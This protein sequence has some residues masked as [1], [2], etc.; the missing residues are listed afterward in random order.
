MEFYGGPEANVIWRTSRLMLYGVQWSARLANTIWSSMEGQE[1]NV[2]RSSMEDQQANS[3]WSSMEVQE[4]NALW[5]AR[6]L[7]LY[8]GPGG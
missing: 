4:A 5:R 1:A 2:I 6:R 7:M 3:I 8:G